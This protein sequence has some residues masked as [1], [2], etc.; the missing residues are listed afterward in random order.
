MGRVDSHVLLLFKKKD[1]SK[2]TTEEKEAESENE[3]YEVTAQ[4]AQATIH[5]VVLNMNEVQQF[6]EAQP[7]LVFTERTA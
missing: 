6:G 3:N 2:K 7:D 1:L 5:Q 4:Q